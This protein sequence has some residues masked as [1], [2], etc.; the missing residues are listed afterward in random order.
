[1]ELTMKDIKT[2]VLNILYMRAGKLS[3]MGQIGYVTG[4]EGQMV[5]PPQLLNL[6]NAEQGQL[7]TRHKCSHQ[8]LGTTQTTISWQVDKPPWHIHP[9]N[10]SPQ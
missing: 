2:A 1:M 3:V 6:A 5:S 10:T 9:W 7:S 8:N 4:L